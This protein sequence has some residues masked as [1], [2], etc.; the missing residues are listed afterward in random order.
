M[1]CWLARARRATVR[2]EAWLLDFNAQSDARDCAH[3]HAQPLRA[4]VRAQ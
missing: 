3:A 4:P 1:V 2:I